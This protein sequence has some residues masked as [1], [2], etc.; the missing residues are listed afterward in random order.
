MNEAQRLV[1]HAISIIAT[2]TQNAIRC[3]ISATLIDPQCADA[4]Y[5]LG[6]IQGE[7]GC[8]EAACV[9]YNKCLDCDP[10]HLK[11][12]VNLSQRA[13]WCGKLDESTLAAERALDLDP[14]NF[15]AYVNL[16]LTQSVRGDTKTALESALK[17]RSIA[18]N[19]QTQL[20]VSFAS[21]YARNP[22]SGLRLHEARY[23]N[24]L[25][26]FLNL[27]WP[28]LL[29]QEID[30][31]SIA[32]ISEQGI[33]DTLSFTRFVPLLAKR[34]ARVELLVHE[35]LNRLMS[36]AM[37][38]Y[39]NVRVRVLAQVYPNVDCWTSFMSLPVPLKLTDEEILSCEDIYWPPFATT[40]DFTR[41]EASLNVGI[42]WAGNKDCAIEKF[43]RVN[44]V[45][46]EPLARVTGVQLYSLQ[47]GE[48]QP[49]IHNTGFSTFITDLSPFIR[50]VAD[51]FGLLQ[52]L[53]L[54]ITTD[55]AVGHMCGALGIPCWIMYSYLGGDF[56][57]GRNED[58]P[59]W[60]T[61]HSIFRQDHRMNW[62]PVIERIR[63]QLESLVHAHDA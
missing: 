6:G 32:V 29:D 35:P 59:W 57:I 25:K 44:L 30:G 13:H 24:Q 31:A 7:L 20:A 41:K 33:G 60:Y 5:W 38:P 62:P 51:T 18:D 1:A 23:E 8:Y 42:C 56:R 37:M 27:P 49:D 55:T 3:L 17:A 26:N 53:D 61:N 58:G 47:V 43:R 2:D 45:D 22:Q 36:A 11:A 34:A 52:K 4:W 54:V 16:S 39:E 63:H 50:D 46:L 19:D 28:R 14:D 10:T 21:L 48:S 12:L 9:L 40:V 15:Q